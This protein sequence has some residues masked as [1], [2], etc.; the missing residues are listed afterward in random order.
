M[1]KITEAPNDLEKNG[2]LDYSQSNY[3]SKAFALDKN[4]N[5]K[6]EHA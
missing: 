5:D 2:D 6:E 1:D 4:E 3:D